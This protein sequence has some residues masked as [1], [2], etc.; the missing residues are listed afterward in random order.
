MKA[1][2]TVVGNPAATVITSLPGLRA[3]SPSLGEVRDANARRLAEAP[4]FEV[5]ANRTPRNLANLFSKASLNLPV[6]SQKSRAESTR[7]CISSAPNTLPDGG[8]T[9]SPGENLGGACR[10]SAYSRDN[11]SI[12]SLRSFS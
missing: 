8:T 5:S 7:L 11:D 1:G 3:L 4:E 12:F 9:V 10:S 6:V 2:F